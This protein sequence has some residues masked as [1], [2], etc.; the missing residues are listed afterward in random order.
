[1]DIE[2]SEIEEIKKELENT[3]TEDIQLMKGLIE[4]ELEKRC[5]DCGITLSTDFEKEDK[6][7]AQC[8][9]AKESKV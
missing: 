6:C 3:S 9:A 7:C 4:Q 1:M 2:V 8:K 5:K